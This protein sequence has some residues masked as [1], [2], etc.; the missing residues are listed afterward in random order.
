MDVGM[1]TAPGF[2]CAGAAII[3]AIGLAMSLAKE[4]QG[5]EA[6]KELS[7]TIQAGAKSFLKTEYFYLSIFV[8]V[9]TILLF[10]VF[11]SNSYRVD[12]TDGARMGLCFV[13]GA[14]LSATAGWFGMQVATDANCRTTAAAADNGPG[15]N[16]LDAA[17]RVAFRGGS[18]MGF[19]VVGLGLFGVCALFCLMTLGRDSDP[20]DD[21]MINAEVLRYQ[22]A[23]SNMSAFGFGASSIALF[24]RVAGGIFTKAADVGADL[25]GKVEADLPEDDPRNPA[26]IADNVGDNVGDVAGMGAD[27]F[28]SFV[29]S[30]IATITLADGDLALIALPIWVSAVGILGSI[31]G[32]NFVY[33]EANA[34]QKQLLHALHRG[35]YAA[36]FVVV[37]G[38]AVLCWLLFQDRVSD[39]Y[40]YFG[41]IIIGLLCGI[42]IG[43]LTE[44]FTSYE[45]YPVKSITDAGVTG[46]ATVIIQGLG[47]GMISCAPP[48]LVLI[49]TIFACA[50]IAG[51]YGV[52][53]AAVGML[54]T[55]G[56]TLAT[57]AY[58]PVADNAGGIA[59]MC[60]LPEHVRKTTD[61]LDALG[62]TTAATGK[63]FAIG[64]AV[65]TSISLM[66]AFQKAS[67]LEGINMGEPIV[68]GGML[69][70]AMLPFLFA[71][72]TMLSVGKAAGAI[73]REVRRQFRDIKGL[74]EG[75]PGVK[76]ESDRCVAECT[77]SSIEEMV[78]PGV[79]AIISPIF[80]GLLIGPA[81]LAGMLGG[82][83]ASG[84]MLA[85]MMSNAGGA[86]DNSKKSIEIEGR[87]GGKG[88]AI[89][90]ACV[91][92]D[93]VGDPFKDTSGPALNILIKLMTVIALTMAPLI[94]GNKDWDNFYF[95]FIPLVIGIATTL[96]YYYNYTAVDYDAP[97][98]KPAGVTEMVNKA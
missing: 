68:F 20:N 50:G 85:V 88:T 5:S 32:Y 17:L 41:C 8:I 19:T 46:P 82:A 77:K 92:G 38:S 72:F 27:L 76:P 67:G 39:G 30:I 55:L 71:A 22:R 3:M 7:A 31:I 21:M 12:D 90:K 10:V 36:T 49:A 94:N 29:G 58:G 18:V 26:T 81:C 13:C 83:I 11:T 87:H 44:I 57:D 79:Y 61:D 54:S 28:E 51:Q 93:T 43:Y 40:R 14:A 15:K 25:V 23:A 37:A 34:T 63:G 95:G 35:V 24:A 84:A 66:S 53:I 80:I 96:Y 52:S 62:N 65:L 78:L 69:F 60:N 89:H 45:Y 97:E 74:R 56:V 16:P 6:M 70:G 98:A 64:S 2:V 9:M 73:I 33:T 42:L 47:I 59:E 86:W 91:V 48:M 75:A 1:I 4:K